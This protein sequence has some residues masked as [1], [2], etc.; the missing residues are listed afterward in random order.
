MIRKTAILNFQLTPVQQI[1]CSI[2]INIVILMPQ[3]DGDEN[4]L[5][6][7]FVYHSNLPNEGARSVIM[8]WEIAFRGLLKQTKRNGKHLAR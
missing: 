5:S 4:W 8:R 3:A 2:T 1:M 6:E 7:M